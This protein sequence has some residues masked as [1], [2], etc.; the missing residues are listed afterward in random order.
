MRDQRRDGPMQAGAVDGIR[1]QVAHDD[2][3]LPGEAAAAAPI[4]TYIS[5]LAAAG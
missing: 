4:V 2:E 1:V 5:T 3:G